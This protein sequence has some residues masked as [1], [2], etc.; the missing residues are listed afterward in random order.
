MRVS[1]N[2]LYLNNVSNMLGKQSAMYKVQ[3]HLS[4]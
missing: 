3:E 4:T 2:S 1:T